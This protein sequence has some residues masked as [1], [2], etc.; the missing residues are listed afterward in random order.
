MLSHGRRLAL[1]THPKVV[2]LPAAATPGDQ[3]AA[4][5]GGHSLYLVREVNGRK[6][7]FMFIGECYMD[8]LMNGAFLEKTQSANQPARPISLI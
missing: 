1:L 5:C 3:I 7:A 4:F 8:G 2:M 6:D